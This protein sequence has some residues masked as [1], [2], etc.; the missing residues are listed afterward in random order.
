MIGEAV[1]LLLSLD[2]TPAPERVRRCFISAPRCGRRP[3]LPCWLAT[4]RAPFVPYATGLACT[5]APNL[6]EKSPVTG[7][8]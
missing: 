8:F 5:M 6:Q 1:R 3:A 4:A 2:K 7:P